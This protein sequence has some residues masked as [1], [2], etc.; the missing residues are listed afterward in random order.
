MSFL[1]PNRKGLAALCC[2]AIVIVL[3][4]PV[5]AE[6]AL[7]PELRAEVEA[8]KQSAA[9]PTTVENYADRSAVLWRW[10]NAF[11]LNGGYVPVNLTT[12]ART[13]VPDAPTVRIL[14][15]V[16]DFIA[17]MTLLDEQPDALGMLS[18]TLGPFAARS[19]ATLQQTYTVG[20]KGIKVGGGFAVSQ[21][22]LTDYGV[23]QASDPQGENYV[24]ISSS[25]PNVHFVADQ[26][27]IS[28]MHGG[29]RGAAKV[30]FFRLSAGQLDPADEVTIT[31]GG[32]A[33]GGPGLLMPTFSSDLMPFPL[34][35]DFDGNGPLFSLP[36]QP[37]RVSGSTVAGVRGFAPSVVRPGEAFTL[38]VRAQDR[39]YNRASGSIPGWKV[40]AGDQVL[41]TLPADESALQTVTDISFT[42]EGVVRLSI[43]SLSGDI[44]G[45]VNPILVSADAQRVYW[46]DTHGHSGFAEGIGTPERFMTWAKED[47]RLDFVT[48]SEHDIW[49]DD[50]E[51]QQLQKNV[52]D[53]SESG[54]FI[55][56]LGYE[57]TTRNIY[58]GHHNV[59]FRTAQQR[60]RLA[61]QFYPT[62]SELYQGLRERYASEDVIVIP[63]AHQA[64]NY[65]LSDPKLQPLVEVMSQHGSFEWFGRKYLEHGHQVGFTAA[66]DNHLSQPGYTAPKQGGSSQ[67]GGLGAVMAP[68]LTRDA[69][70]DN[71]RQ[72]HTY[73]TTGERIIL[74]AGVN[75]LDMGQ[76]GEFA[77]TRSVAGRVIGTAP[78][79]EIA[80]VKNGEVV[81]SKDYIEPQQSQ[82]FSSEETFY[83]TFNSASVPAQTGDNPRGWR[84]W[85]G[86]LKVTDANLVDI[87]MADS[88]AADAQ[89]PRRDEDDSNKAY[90][91]TATRGDSS[92]IALTLSDIRRGARVE[93]QLQQA[94]EFGSGPPIF[95]RHQK[96]PATEVEL[97]VADVKRD[98]ARAKI[99]FGSY[100]DSIGLRRVVAGGPM[101]MAFEWRDENGL[102][103]DNY[104]VR[105]TQ[106]DGA[107]A[108]S[109]PIWVGG[110]ASR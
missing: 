24:S 107:M 79:A 20:T 33:Q 90:F 5:H 76:R 34:Y 53:F 74:Q 93:L 45:S 13:K 99:S 70:F 31:Y 62:L 51:W 2:L 66:S 28:G 11:A 46:G 80:V 32:R 37:I 21:H 63:H 58:G 57:W 25:N 49:M 23:F 14:R 88:F 26:V 52:Q 86:S 71:M 10:A 61:T 56:Y 81:W 44:V 29:F 92:S 91:A 30:L 4:S 3:Q 40:L 47:A 100:E 59:L 38:S 95:R 87:Q 82:R 102:Q 43:Q 96:V 89:K 75:G 83:L 42:D 105:V 35:V 72:R 103:G 9:A 27:P 97:A 15:G 98:G 39:Y 109:S 106:L 84:P 77:Q 101:E 1:A 16:D 41:A 22:F 18:A 64:G 19:R 78:I 55:A 36:I 104:Y 6:D 48:H 94:V 108:W 73:A 67:R 12:V 65:R 68:E 60:D 110:Y 69:L 8:L 7:S 85:L 17:E 54:R 50:F